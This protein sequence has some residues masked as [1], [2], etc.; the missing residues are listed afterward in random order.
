M[1]RG[2]VR[3]LENEVMPKV[4]V[5]FD[6][7]DQR[8]AGF[9]DLAAE[10]AKSVKFTEVDIRVVGDDASDGS[11]RR[12]LESADVSHYDGVVVAG[13]D[14]DISAS[15][16]AV[17]T[18]AGHS[19]GEFVDRVFAAVGEGTT[20]GRRLAELGGIVVGVRAGPADAD[21]S[22]RKTGERV[23]KVVEWVRHS[24]SHEHGHGT[25]HHAHG[26]HHSH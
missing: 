24:L 8:A 25:A 13:S 2:L 19:H 5:L 15:I 16:E 20:I 4:L 18:K 14:R 1:T 12:R 6:S 10:G 9:A 7:A 26:H 17:L 11:N 21:Q 23:A 22:A 3:M